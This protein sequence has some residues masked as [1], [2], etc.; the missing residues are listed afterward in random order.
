MS[1]APALF[2][3]AVRRLRRDRAA[4][5][6]G[7]ADFLLREIC[8]R[9][10]ERLEDILRQFPRAAIVGAW[11]G[12]PARILGGRFGIETLIQIESSP[13]MAAKAAAFG[14]VAVAD[15]E[16]VP[17][18]EG[19]FD[20]IL[21]PLT[22]HGVNDLPG[23]L[24]Q[25]RRAL[26]P[27]G[28]FLGALWAGESLHHLR[29]AFAEAE[30]G[31]TGGLSPRV[32]PFADLRSLGALLQRAGFALPAA[33]LDRIEA[34]YREPL[35]LLRDLK[36]MGESNPLRERRRAFLRRGVLLRA[37]EILMLETPGGGPVRAKFDV[38]FLT[39]WSPHESQQ[40]PLKPGSAK[41]RLAE[42][43]KV[44][45]HPLDDK[46]DSRQPDPQ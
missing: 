35:R 2:D 20:L 38:A 24:T 7:E 32:A 42:A 26:K 28:L 44:P 33:D 36:A 25:I 39:G 3:S 21:A 27:D 10:G 8:E 18:K 1:S 30:I 11:D 19:S 16:A 15:E 9:L 23:A 31:V 34:T 37:L 46:P 40:K 45:E 41:H 14:P 5:G 17:L 13:R 6:F 29:M 22:L 12:T 43:L 4:E